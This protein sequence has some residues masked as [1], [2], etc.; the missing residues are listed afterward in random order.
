MNPLAPVVEAQR[1]QIALLRGE[2]NARTAQLELARQQPH[3][4]PNVV[5]PQAR[6]RAEAQVW[7]D[8]IG[9]D[10]DAAHHRDFLETF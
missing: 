1:R 3:R 6:A 9:P 4:D 2:V 10:P 7:L 8:R 5:T